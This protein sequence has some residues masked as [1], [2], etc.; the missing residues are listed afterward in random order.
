MSQSG[1]GIVGFLIGVVF[2]LIL[3][4]LIIAAITYAKRN[5]FGIDY[6]EALDRYCENLGPIE[7]REEVYIPENPSIY[8]KTLATALLDIALATS[9]SYCKT[10]DPLP[11]PPGFTDQMP[12][13]R[14]KT[15]LGHIFWNDTYACISFT[16]TMTIPEWGA[17]FDYRLIPATALN[18]YVPGVACHRGFYFLYLAIR[19]QIW[20]WINENPG[21]T[22]FITGHSLGGALSTISAYD[23]ALLTPIHYSFAAPRSGNVNYATQFNELLPQSL[24]I[25]NTEDIVP[26]LPPATW[27]GNTFEHTNNSIPFT[28]SLGSLAQDHVKAYKDDMPECFNNH[29]PCV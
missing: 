21:K 14:G 1:L 29:A 9:Q 12:L 27:R 6:Q 4:I 7:Y 19:G 5:S 10:V 13:G 28:K 17:D 18:N 20:D 16:G 3:L 23:L 15:R 26:Q 11:L 8:E 22:I 25:N 2:V 24:R